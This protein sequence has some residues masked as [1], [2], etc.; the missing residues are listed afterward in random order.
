MAVAP[1]ILNQPLNGVP[2]EI[3]NSNAIKTCGIRLRLLQLEQLHV[4]AQ[5]ENPWFFRVQSCIAIV[6]FK[7]SQ[8]AA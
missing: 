2:S 5:D 3:I 7:G 4:G 1:K 6:A 8:S